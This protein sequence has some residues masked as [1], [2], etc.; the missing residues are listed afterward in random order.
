MKP[1]ALTVTAPRNRGVIRIGV[2]TLGHPALAILTHLEYRVLTLIW[3]W[4]ARHGKDGEVPRDWL[5]G[6]PLGWV[7]GRQLRLRPKMLKRFVSLGLLEEW[8]NDDDGERVIV[9]VG[10]RSF[11]P[12]DLT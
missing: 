7:Q 5:L 8:V 4:V 1:R 11:R 6:L 10:W 2:E 9:V 3:V 12:V